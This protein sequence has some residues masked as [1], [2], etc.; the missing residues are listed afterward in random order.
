MLMLSQVQPCVLRCALLRNFSSSLNLCSTP[1]QLF[2]HLIRN[3][4][5]PI[6]LRLSNFS[7]SGRFRDHSAASHL[8]IGNFSLTSPSLSNSLTYL[9]SFSL[10]SC[11]LC[12][13]YFC[14][15]S[16]LLSS[17]HFGTLGYHHCLSSF[18]FFCDFLHHS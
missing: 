7:A 11:E 4:F 8:S 17:V 16:S 13:G 10:S 18:I 15:L 6:I 1:H 9:L 2:P 14:S 3:H 12:G 5:T